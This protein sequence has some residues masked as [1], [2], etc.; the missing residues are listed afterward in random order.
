LQAVL[1]DALGPDALHLGAACTGFTQDDSGVTAQF[2]DG[3]TARG[4]LLIGA[5]GLHSV[6]RAQLHGGQPPTYVGYTAW[7]AVIPFDHARLTPGE[8]SGYGPRF[9]QVPISGG[10]VYWFATQN[11]PAGQRSPDGEQAA[12]RRIFANWHAPIPDLIR[13]T[14]EALIL[15]NDIYDR[16]PLR[17]WGQGRVTLLGDAAHPMTPNLGQGGCQAL[18]DAVVLAA[19]LCAAPAVPAALRA[20]E[21]RRI[22]RTS[23]IVRQSRQAGQIGQ[24]AN[25]L[26]VR[27]REWLFRVAGPRF[28][29]RMLDP[30]LRYEL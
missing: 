1:R 29:P 20:Y 17:A 8:S 19:C 24:W 10:R 2:A 6:V 21:A 9:G 18:E 11:T 14:P 28:Q 5:D 25:P 13:A 3:R 12:L 30:I 15:R 23:A 16:P 22:P 26:A 7:R 4:D 27:V